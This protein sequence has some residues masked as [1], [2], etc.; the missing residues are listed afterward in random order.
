MRSGLAFDRFEPIG[1]PLGWLYTAP[2]TPESRL[3]SS[4]HDANPLV[5]ALTKVTYTQR[6][7]SRLN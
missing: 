7:T 6:P 4:D 2:A 1:E 3:M 5:T